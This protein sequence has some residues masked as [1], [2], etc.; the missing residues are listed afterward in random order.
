MV[1]KNVLEARLVIDQLTKSLKVNRE[2]TKIN[3][4]KVKNLSQMIDA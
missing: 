4:E 3:E 2:H 1:F